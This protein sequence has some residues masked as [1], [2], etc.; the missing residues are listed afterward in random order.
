MQP[1][2]CITCLVILTPSSWVGDNS[3]CLSFAGEVAAM[4]VKEN[5]DFASLALSHHDKLWV[6]NIIHLLLL[7]LFVVVI[8]VIV[9]LLLLLFRFE[10]SD[11][12]LYSHC[13]GGAVSKNLAWQAYTSYIGTVRACLWVGGWMVGGWMVGGWMVSGWMVGGWMVGRWMV[14]EWLVDGWMNG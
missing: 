13:G 14:G 11:E 8:V 1:W 7:L 10:S 2:M 6:L 9:L 12:R 5:I 4:I 3:V